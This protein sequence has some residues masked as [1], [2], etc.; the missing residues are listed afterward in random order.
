[1]TIVIQDLSMTEGL[2][3]RALS[4]AR[5]GMNIQPAP[6]PWGPYLPQVPC[7][8]IDFPFHPVLPIAR[9]EAP[10]CPPAGSNMDPRLQ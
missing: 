1:M 10:G 7:L 3:R 4:A 6:A 8:P 5:G 9:V 2:D